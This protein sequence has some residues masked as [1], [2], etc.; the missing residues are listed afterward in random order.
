MNKI[1]LHSCCAPCSTSSSFDLRKKGFEPILFFYN[2]NIHP[3]NEYKKRVEEIEKWAQINNFNLIV[4]EY[5]K[6]RWFE[7]MRGLEQEPEGGKRCQKCY[8]M[9]LEKT[10]EVAKANGIKLITTT[11]TIS[12]HKKAEIINEIGQKLCKEN[13]LEYWNSNFKKQ[14]G[15]LNSCKLS[16][17]HGFYRQDYCGCIFSMK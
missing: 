15:Y 14:N 3:I 8:A 12:P 6:D 2:P 7:M 11:L 9:R 16:E 1:L 13:N 5:D 10:A 4:G 17:K